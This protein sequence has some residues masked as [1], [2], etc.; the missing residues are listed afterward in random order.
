ME[1]DGIMLS[2][3]S[4][5]EKD[6]YQWFH[7]YVEYKNKG[8]LKEQNSSRI[9]EPKNGLTVTKGKGT[10]QDGWERK[11]KGREKKWETMIDMYNV[12]GGMGRAVQHREDK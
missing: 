3:I 8:K 11:E 4:Q 7:S 6:K 9:K 10:G 5:V 12:D 2:E 1:L